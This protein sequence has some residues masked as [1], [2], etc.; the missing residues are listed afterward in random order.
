V[1]DGGLARDLLAEVP[2]AELDEQRRRALGRAGRL[3][4]DSTPRGPRQ[5]LAGDPRDRALLGPEQLDLLRRDRGGAVTDERRRIGAHGGRSDAQRQRP[6]GRTAERHVVAVADA[7]AG[8]SRADGVEGERHRR[9]PG[10]LSVLDGRLPALALGWRGNGVGPRRYGL[11]RLAVVGL[12]R[13]LGIG[14]SGRRG[15]G[16]GAFR[17]TRRSEPGD[18]EQPSV[19]LHRRTVVERMPRRDAV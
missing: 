5:A 13:L 4:D 2:D 10:G 14:L 18:D 15:I 1:L 9:Q 8:H 6:P 11:R 12:A 3:H 16:L 17:G 7:I 19:A